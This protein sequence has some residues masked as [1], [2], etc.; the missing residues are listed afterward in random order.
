M[1]QR[2]WNSAGLACVLFAHSLCLREGVPAWDGLEPYIPMLLAGA[3]IGALTS[4]MVLPWLR[5]RGIRGAA[6][7]LLPGMFAAFCC[8]CGAYW[9][10]PS[11]VALGCACA[12][13]PLAFFLENIRLSYHMRG[14]FLGCVLAVVTLVGMLP[15]VFNLHLDVQNV[16]LPGLALLLTFS[17]LCAALSSPAISHKQPDRRNTLD[18][19]LSWQTL[20]YLT[21]IA[22]TFFLLN[23]VMDWLFYRM[24]A[25][26]FPIPQEVYLYLWVVYPL[27]GYWLDRR[28]TDIRVLLCCLA[29]VIMAPL[30][31]L[32]F[33]DNVVYWLLYT[34][35]LSV[36]AVAL[37]YLQLVFMQLL[38]TSDLPCGIVLV[39][40]WLCF[41]CSFTAIRGFLQIFP[42]IVPFFCLMWVLTAS[43]SFIASRIQYALTLAGAITIASSVK[44]ETAEDAY[45]AVAL[46]LFSSKYGI[47]KREQ[48]V[49]ALIVAGK[50]TSEMAQTLNISENTVKSH[51][52]QLLRKTA[53]RNRIFLLTLFFR[54][55][56]HEE[57]QGEG[58]MSAVP[59]SGRESNLPLTEYTS[60]MSGRK[61]RSSL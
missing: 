60:V 44:H 12:S 50:G 9:Q 20:C 8:L 58:M 36:R 57:S 48:D 18:R 42:G 17:G 55:S 13:F 47:S 53:T 3:M 21:G 5:M 39:L 40:P 25:R 22:L 32:P 19:K 14:C 43:F 15:T 31:T 27:F 23:A 7:R 46:G 54:E 24:H 59:A 10:Q 6:M 45:P 61:R 11:L 56:G 33:E 35:D 41:L 30:V 51:V 26:E 2:F 4:A 16:V 29:F 49:L 1:L 37:L 52:R 34:L 28:G 38:K